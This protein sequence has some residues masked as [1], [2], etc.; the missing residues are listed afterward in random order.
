MLVFFKLRNQFIIR[1]KK[2]NSPLKRTWAVYAHCPQPRG[3]SNPGP[4]DHA[5][6]PTSFHKPIPSIKPSLKPIEAP[7]FLKGKSERYR[8]KEM[9]LHQ[10][11]MDR[12]IN[13]EIYVLLVIYQECLVSFTLGVRWLVFWLVGWLTPSRTNEG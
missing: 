11:L 2:H 4:R 1:S 3:E 5:S 12:L 7:S 6:S 9:L 13:L 10:T 8:E